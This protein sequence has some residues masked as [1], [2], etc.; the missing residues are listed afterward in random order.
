MLKKNNFFGNYFTNSKKYRK[1]VNKTK[2]V[3]KSF[4]SDFNNNEIPFL[5]SFDKEYEFTFLPSTVKKFSKY[6]NIIIIGMG[7]SILGAK[8][9]YSFLKKKINKK[10]FFF[11]NLD[12]NLNLKY[13]NIKNLN[14]SCFVIISKSGNTIE[15][16]TNLGI[17]FSK[18]LLRNKM[19]IITQSSN[20]ELIAFANRYNA[21]IIEH[22]EYIGGRYS[23]LSE[24]GMFPAALMG[25]NLK[26]FKNFKFLIKNK[27]F[28]DSLIQNVA[29]IYTLKQ[30]NFDN[31]VILNY[32]SNLNNIGYWYQ[33][34]TAE[35]LGK[36]RNGITPMLSFCP[37]DH[38]SLLQLYI[39][40][41]K[42][43]FFTFFNAKSKKDKYKIS[44]GIISKNSN[45]LANK[46]MNLVIN[47]QSKATKRVFKLKKI[48]FREI[49][50][51][52]I[53]EEELGMIFSFF[54]LET[55]LLSR[56]MNV[57]PF[58]QPAVEEVKV[59]AKKLLR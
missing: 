43:K 48:P 53:D 23:V 17:I 37:K 26:K 41:P 31:S 27:N 22:R 57:N 39:D 24:A 9:I 52:K 40:G 13:K 44:R 38:H 12:A 3:F 14:N 21:E 47:A 25:L 36:Q 50:F 55:I 11:D 49:T 34:L 59:E 10:V 46:S 4:L 51:N 33:Q 18:K 28:I 56:L 15:T 29:S 35:S 8:G 54:V 42:N 45:F 2:K 32:D 1:N 20:S 7:G 30:M 5:E 16:I 58:D 19:V 6:K